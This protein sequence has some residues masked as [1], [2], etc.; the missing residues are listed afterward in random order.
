MSK[1][2]DPPIPGLV[3]QHPRVCPCTGGVGRQSRGWTPLDW[4]EVRGVSSLPWRSQVGHRSERKERPV[5]GHSPEVRSGERALG[6]EGL[7]E[8]EAAIP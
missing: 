2:V 4:R 1:K 7:V 6:T 5:K 3:I 8:S